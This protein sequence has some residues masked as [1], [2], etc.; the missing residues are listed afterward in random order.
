MD[1]QALISSTQNH[2][3]TGGCIVAPC[4][5]DTPDTSAL[6]ESQ[7]CFDD[8][9]KTHS[10][11]LIEWKGPRTDPAA[12]LHDSSGLKRHSGQ[13]GVACV[14]CG[15]SFHLKAALQRLRHA[16]QALEV[17][18]RRKVILGM[19]PCL[20][21]ALTRF[22]ECAPP[23]NGTSL[24]HRARQ[25]RQRPCRKPA[26]WKRRGLPLSGFAGVRAIAGA[27]TMKYRAY[28]D[29]KALRFYT[30]LQP[31][32]SVAV[33]QHALLA[34][35]RA[36]LQAAADVD[37]QAWHR[38]K[39]LYVMC[40]EILRSG[41]GSEEILG[42]G[43]YVSLRVNEWLGRKHHITSPRLPLMEALQVHS[44]I[45]RARLVSWK[46]VRLE[47]AHFMQHKKR[48]LTCGLN[49][50][51]AEA[52]ANKA[53]SEVAAK[54]LPRILRSALHRLHREQRRALRGLRTQQ[55]HKSKQARAEAGARRAQ[56]SA[57]RERGAERRRW[58]GRGD[59]TM[60][61][62]LRGPPMHPSAAREAPRVPRSPH[63]LPLSFSPL[64]AFLSRVAPQKGGDSGPCPVLASAHGHMY[65]QRYAL[66]V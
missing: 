26:G 37:A 19:D 6:R 44:R 20:K 47:W 33:E 32:A 43:V 25:E 53:R 61:E 55:Y 57:A 49:L 1:S 59:L 58:F 2:L 64:P 48:G 60:E 5:R 18:A 45:L 52:I 27:Q 21:A 17:P 16:L 15:T 8:V 54:K 10:Q 50:P 31:H 56:A 35:M 39:D 28:M 12:R 62:I 40:S 22:M 34:R 46:A 42:L 41:G 65:S 14:S 11:K 36:A 30:R 3:S 63:T 29:V 24:L 38:V 9:A 7:G 13:A 23:A 51:E 4:Q 66:H